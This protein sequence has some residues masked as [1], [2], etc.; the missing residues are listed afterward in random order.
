M[1]EAPFLPADCSQ[2]RPQV[3]GKLRSWP[4]DPWMAPWSCPDCHHGGTSR[5][6]KALSRS[7]SL[8]RLHRP[9]LSLGLQ[10]A[11]LR[12][13]EFLG[14]SGGGFRLRCLK[15]KG[16]A[17]EGKRTLKHFRSQ[18][19]LE[20]FMTWPGKRMFLSTISEALAELH[21]LSAPPKAPQGG[22]EGPLG[23]QV[24]LPGDGGEL[25]GGVESHRSTLATRRFGCSSQRI[26]KN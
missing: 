25:P 11:S 16:V 24:E 18:R 12:A 9:S 1:S 7:G 5:S 2:L 14:C 20:A 15:K 26:S 6:G 19:P 22:G 3:L 4:L 23:A 17:L 8:S 21:G 13:Q 10:T